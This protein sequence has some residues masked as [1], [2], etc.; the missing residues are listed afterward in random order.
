MDR[1]LIVAAYPGD[2]I[3]GCY[4]VLLDNKPAGA[5]DVL[6]AVPSLGAGQEA[7]S[8]ALDLGFQLYACEEDSPI[9]ERAY[10]AVYVPSRRDKDPGRRQVAAAYRDTAT[11]FYH[12]NSDPMYSHRADIRTVSPEAKLRHY[13]THYFPRKEW[14]PVRLMDYWSMEAFEDTDH[15]RSSVVRLRNGWTAEVP[16]HHAPSVRA[17]LS[18]R[19]PGDSPEELFD[20]LLR[21]CPDGPVGL[22]AAQQRLSS[23]A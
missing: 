10:R 12:V 17:V 7:K 1:T 13:M 18:E 22:T 23:G 11:H 16:E 6:F 21:V 20:L 8:A 2:E 9:A 19:G 4:S 3:L 5:C 14:P 15:T